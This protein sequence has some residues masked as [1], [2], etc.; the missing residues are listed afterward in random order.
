[1]LNIPIDRGDGHTLETGGVRIFSQVPGRLVGV[2]W[3]NVKPIAAMP[4]TP[5][6]GRAYY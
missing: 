3:Y 4:T 5:E 2:Y 6:R 1:M